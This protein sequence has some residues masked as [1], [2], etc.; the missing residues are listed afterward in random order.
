MI[1][2][3]LSF[4]FSAVTAVRTHYNMERTKAQ[5]KEYVRNLWK[6]KLIYRKYPTGNY[7]QIK[8]W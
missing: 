4:H 2:A 7:I 5:E 3:P 8:I 6:E 1:N